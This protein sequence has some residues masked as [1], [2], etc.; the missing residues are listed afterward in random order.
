MDVGIG[1]VVGEGPNISAHE[2]HVLLFFILS[3][4]SAL[5]PL[6]PRDQERVIFNHLLF[7]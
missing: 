3:A 4:W 6:C 2:R 7:F 1:G 5:L